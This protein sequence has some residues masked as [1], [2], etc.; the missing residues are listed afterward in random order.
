MHLHVAP[1]LML[2]RPTRTISACENLGLPYIDDI[3]SPSHPPFGCGRL[4]F[5]RDNNAHR[6]STYHAFLPKQLA[7]R[8][9]SNLH[10]CTGTIVEKLDINAQ[11]K[12]QGVYLSS[13]RSTK[14]VRVVREVVLSAGPFASPQILMLR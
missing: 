10:I 7:I 2:T 13:G 4:H 5:T 11:R 14:L 6:S 8:R 12:V 3:N 9:K 1:Q